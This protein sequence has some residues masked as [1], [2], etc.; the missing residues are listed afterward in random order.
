MAD[1]GAGEGAQVAPVRTADVVSALCLAT[2]L[3]M[4]F[5]WEHGLHANRI[6]MRIA[7]VLGLDAET[8]RE[9]YYV[10]LLLYVG[11]TVDADERVHLFGGSV[12]D[13]FIP[14][15]WGS[16]REQL[17]GLARAVAS[18]AAS[19]VPRAVQVV[20]RLPRAAAGHPR[21]EAALCEVAEMLAERLGLPESVHARFFHLTDRWDGT[22][23]LHRG[24][25]EEIPLAL[26]VATVARDAAYQRLLGGVDHA[27]EVLANR[28][29][30]AFDPTVVAAVLEHAD[31]VLEQVSEG[32]VWEENLAA[33]P[34]PWLTLTP[35]AT[36]R[37]LAAVGDFADLVSP[38]LAGHAAGVSALAH[39]AGRLL[40]LSTAEC[41]LVRRAGLVA[42]V[43]RV[44]VPPRAWE[45]AGPLT[46]DEREH[47]RLHP[48]YTERILEQSSVLAPLAAPAV[49]HHERLD[50]SGY[51]RG[52]TA[53]ML[54]TPA[55]LLAVADAYRSMTESRASRPAMS[56]DDA[57]RHLVREV[58]EHRLDA[59]A[60]EAVLEA[61]GRPVPALTR[62]HG[63]TRREAEVVGL[64]A[65]GRQTKQI[66]RTLGIS[67]KT[68]DRHIEHAYR[69][70]GVS[71]RAA[72]TLFAMEHGLVPWGELPMSPSEAGS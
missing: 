70:M 8:T 28:A 2:D 15:L 4:R 34:E 9:A 64:L 51:H 19:P 43:G 55:R 48:Y 36:D 41:S 56:A 44:T 27:R 46:A 60:V 49:C 66:A 57:A 32:S 54:S 29:G 67:P 3:A 6:A 24:S 71:T 53:P 18:P 31:E 33:E 10:T 40:G 20:T 1:D 12:T 58:D 52:L 63:L 42:D 45:R 14:R 68:A 38:H 25:G 61:A 7:R 59:D 11:C 5:P 13:S 62:P 35:S 26:R 39:G 17:T 23:A 69:K 16:R 30:H 72:A 21:H 37:A 47:V 50:G 65:R 22:D